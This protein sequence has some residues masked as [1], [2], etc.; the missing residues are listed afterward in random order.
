M[1]RVRCAFRSMAKACPVFDAFRC[2]TAIRESGI[3][4][5]LPYGETQCKSIADISIARP[6]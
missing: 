1:T 5:V 4:L 2:S 3:R 6:I